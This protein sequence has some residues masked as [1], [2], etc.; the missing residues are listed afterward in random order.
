MNPIRFVADMLHLAAILIL[1]Y[2]IRKTRNCI[3]KLISLPSGQTKQFGFLTR[4]QFRFILQNTRV[5]LT[6]VRGALLRLILV[7]HLRL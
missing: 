5:V 2:R 6:H 1:M 7:L 3:G 4:F